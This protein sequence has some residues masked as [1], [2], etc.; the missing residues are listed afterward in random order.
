MSHVDLVG[1]EHVVE[2]EAKLVVGDAHAAVLA[3]NR[4]F[5]QCGPPSYELVYNPI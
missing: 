5:I 4:G 1:A 2:V 3:S